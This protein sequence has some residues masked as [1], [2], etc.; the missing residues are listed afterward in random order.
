MTFPRDRIELFKSAIAEL[1]W[2]E[3]TLKNPV[4]HKSDS[5]RL[6]KEKQERH[7][8]M[9]ETFGPFP[10][11]PV[12]NEKGYRGGYQIQNWFDDE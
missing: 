5:E 6:S 3:E 2:Y 8:W 4:L 7:E 10:G 1:Q 9:I 12:G 11:A